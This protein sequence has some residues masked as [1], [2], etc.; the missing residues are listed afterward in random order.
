LK[1]TEESDLALAFAAILLMH[2]HDV[3][4]LGL[5]EPMLSRKRFAS[6]NA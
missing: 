2:L 3:R 5:P 1:L 4:H 6:L